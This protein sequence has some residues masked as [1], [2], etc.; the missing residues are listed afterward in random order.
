MSGWKLGLA[1]LSLVTTINVPT[2]WFWRCVSW[3][4]WRTDD[5]Y[6]DDYVQMRCITINIR[7]TVI[8]KAK[9]FNHSKSANLSRSFF[10]TRKVALKIM[11]VNERPV[12]KMYKSPC[13]GQVELRL[14]IGLCV[15]CVLS[16]YRCLQNGIISAGTWLCVNDSFVLHQKVSIVI[17]P[18]ALFFFF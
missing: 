11:V 1:S 18:T 10:N 5:V 9:V 3:W 4:F 6:H 8:W 7:I 13:S 14:H 17:T 12:S 15:Q 2:W 16:L